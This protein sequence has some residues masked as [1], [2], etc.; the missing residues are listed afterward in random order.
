MKCGGRRGSDQIR[1]RVTD[2]RLDL[3]F[4]P[5]V[6]MGS[7]YR[8]ELKTKKHWWASPARIASFTARSAAHFRGSGLG[9]VNL[10]SL[11]TVIICQIRL[12]RAARRRPTMK[13]VGTLN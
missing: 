8:R 4:S 2:S 13:F 10:P 3:S 12:D 7:G 5:G 6:Q 1:V 9:W 11:C